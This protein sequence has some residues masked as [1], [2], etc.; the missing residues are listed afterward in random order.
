MN[1]LQIINISQAIILQFQNLK[2][3]VHNCEA[4]IY[5]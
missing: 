4:I 3:L 1:H 2:Q 5:F